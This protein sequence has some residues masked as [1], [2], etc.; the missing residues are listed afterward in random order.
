[1]TKSNQLLRSLLLVNSTMPEMDQQVSNKPLILFLDNLLRGI[2]QICLMNNLLTGL[3]IL[4]AITIGELRHGF[5][6]F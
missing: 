6:A 2:G 5:T 4:V 3:L 1:M